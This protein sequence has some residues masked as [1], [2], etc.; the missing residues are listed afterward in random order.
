MIT[1]NNEAPRQHAADVAAAQSLVEGG[2]VSGVIALDTADAEILAAMDDPAITPDDASVD[3]SS[4][5]LTGKL[6][7][8]N[9]ANLTE[10]ILSSNSFGSNIPHINTCTA[11][12]ELHLED[13]GLTSLPDMSA[14]SAVTDVVVD[15]N[16]GIIDFS[17]LD[18]LEALLTLSAVECT[19]MADEGAT[20]PDLSASSVLEGVY[21]YNCGLAAG[22][23]DE[24]IADLSATTVE[25][26]DLNLTGNSP[27][28]DTES[29]DTL[30]WLVTTR[31]W[32]V[33]VDTPVSV[34]GTTGGEG[35][36]AAQ[37]YE[38]DDDTATWQGEEDGYYIYNNGG[39]WMLW[40]GAHAGTWAKD[41]QQ[42]TM[43]GDY[44]LAGHTTITISAAS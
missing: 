6:F 27:P 12:E 3:L 41:E 28:S 9:M 13:C 37:K 25:E 35:G 43:L 24:L 10:L 1:V 4:A 8:A 14:L 44:K 22:Q 15:S 11:L 7:V 42:T 16:P 31:T 32:D 21:I 38:W 26:G 19:G 2:C 23:V 30:Y 17:P 39:T 29:F 20:L 40:D 18:D 34:Q 5:G 36:P 33:D